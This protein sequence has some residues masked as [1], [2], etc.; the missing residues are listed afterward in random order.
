MKKVKGPD[1]ED[2]MMPEVLNVNVPQKAPC[3]ACGGLPIMISISAS[4]RSASPFHSGMQSTRK[5]P[6]DKDSWKGDGKCREC[7]GT[8]YV[9]KGQSPTTGEQRFAFRRPRRFPAHT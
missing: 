5:D 2:K 9:R 3:E 7:K 6:G 8:G 4:N 1:G